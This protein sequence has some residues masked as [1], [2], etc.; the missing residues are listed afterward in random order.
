[1]SDQVCVILINW[2]GWRDTIECLQSLNQVEFPRL[3]VVV[4]DNGSSDDSVAQI[5]K[6]CEQTDIPYTVC[7]GRHP[8]VV[9]QP[10]GTPMSRQRGIGRLL[11]LALDQNIGFCAGNNVGMKQAFA[12]GAD[13]LLILNNDTHV[14][15]GFLRPLVEVAKR[16]R[17]VG[18]VGGLICYAE[19][20]DRIWFAG[21]TF[22][23]YLESVRRLDGKLISDVD[24][25]KTLDTDWVSGCM[26]LV[27]RSIYEELG[28]FD[29]R[30]FIW[31][32]EWDYSLRVKA[33]GYR[34][35][36]ATDAKV[37]HKVGRSL[38]VMK[39]LSYYYG[40]RNRLLLKQ[41]YL[42][43]HLQVAFLTWFL[44]S[45][46]I[47]YSQFALH[48]RWDLVQAGSAALWDYFRGRTGKW[49]QQSN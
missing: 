19:E 14:T 33:A 17:R 27:P 47:R 23:K 6:W 45:R 4:V 30:F 46:L 49:R 40:T 15:P 42:P 41:M 36:V 25:A 38:G 9:P 43:V 31:S 34:L 2:N 35:V 22:D 28:G 24:L 16:E 32:E 26:M 10:N 21:G 12:N 39:P 18:L 44:F 8:E 48:A 13:F 11:M 5:R 3:Q 29:E 37:Y 1:M 7:F 20:P